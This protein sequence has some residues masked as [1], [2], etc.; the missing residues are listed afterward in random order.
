MYSI[1]F[2]PAAFKVSLNL[3]F[4]ILTVMCLSVVSFAFILLAVGCN[5]SLGKVSS[6]TSLNIV[7]AHSL[8][9]LLLLL[10]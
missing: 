3:A 4:K 9:P 8:S 1:F 10:Q 2:S 5:S 7:S 6:V